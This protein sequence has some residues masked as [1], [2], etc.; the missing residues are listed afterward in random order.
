MKSRKSWNASEI[1]TEWSCS[2]S[3]LSEL[4]IS[5]SS[6]K[7]VKMINDVLIYKPAGQ[8]TNLVAGQYIYIYYVV[9]DFNPWKLIVHMFLFTI[10]IS[11]SNIDKY[12]KLLV[13]IDVF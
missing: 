5:E 2:I 7:T 9:C 13:N 10:G 4:L 8:G 6:Y 1:L 12:N 11:N 3:L